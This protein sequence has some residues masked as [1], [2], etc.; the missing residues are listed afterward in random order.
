MYLHGKNTILNN[1]LYQTS[2][3][4]KYSLSEI[5]ALA[6]IL[7][8][9]SKQKIRIQS[10]FSSNYDRWFTLIHLPWLNW[11]NKPLCHL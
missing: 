8:C 1:T 10:L 5:L 11:S 7:I 9:F 4:I 6:L 3:E 2:E